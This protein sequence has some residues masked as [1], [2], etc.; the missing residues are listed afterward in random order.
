[1]KGK[2][3]VMGQAAKKV[4][5]VDDEADVRQFVMVA[6]EEDGYAFL[7]AEDG[8]AA[9]KIAGAEKPDVVIMD[10]QMPK[11]D[12]F[13]AFYDLRNSEGTKSIPVIM[14]TAV[15]ERTGIKFDAKDM[16]DYLGSE[17]EAYID[18]PIDPEK[19]QETV[20]KIVG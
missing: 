1:M 8:E 6:L 15:A 10:V 18:K 7:E 9:V 16:G 2:E 12:G 4:L 5:I 17:P 14:L 20:A 11:K 3:R 13:Q 19:L